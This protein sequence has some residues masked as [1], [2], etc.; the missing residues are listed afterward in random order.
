MSVGGPLQQL[1]GGLIGFFDRPWLDVVRDVADILAV[2]V[3][4]YGVLV[5]LRGTRAMRMAVVLAAVFVLH[6][7]AR[8]LGLV[9]V[10]AMLDA[11]LVYVVLIVV[12]L[13]QHDIRRAMARL[14]GRSWWRP[15]WG[16]RET[17]AVEEVV[18]AAVMLASKRI[19]AIVVFERSIDLEDLVQEGTLLDA[20]V[21]RELLFGLF[22]PSYQNP[23]HDGAA[24]V[25]EGRL[26]KAGVLLPLSA[27]PGLDRSLGTRHRAALGISEESDAIA[28]VVSEERGA[29]SLCFGG[30]IVRGLDE[31]AL[32]EALLEHFRGE[33]SDRAPARSPSVTGADSESGRATSPSLEERATQVEPTAGSGHATARAEESV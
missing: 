8:W 16:A 27:R 20:V 12:I 30:S 26:W 15:R 10:W 14:G 7:V 4:V 11:L 29:I 31:K 25:R 23:L 28:V 22:V 13:F 1:F 24:V 3:V 2:S 32:R 33:S 18:K 17:Q 5:V 21:S 19:G 9:T 6:Q